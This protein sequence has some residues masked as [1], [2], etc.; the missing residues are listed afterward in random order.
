MNEER[1]KRGAIRRWWDVLNNELF[2]F[3]QYGKLQ[4]RYSISFS[5]ES[6]I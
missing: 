2:R 3:S 1:N 6:V 5:E 4:T